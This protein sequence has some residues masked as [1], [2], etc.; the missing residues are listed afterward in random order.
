[1][2]DA[3]KVTLAVSATISNS[4]DVVCELTCG[5]NQA[6]VTFGKDEVLFEAPELPAGE[7]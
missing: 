7:Q 6:K 5:G 4:G 1:M 3:V 2:G